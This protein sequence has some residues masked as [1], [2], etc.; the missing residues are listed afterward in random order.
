M[1]FV[2]LSGRRYRRSGVITARHTPL[3][4]GRQALKNV[5]ESTKTNPKTRANAK[6][7]LAKQK[8][9]KKRKKQRKQQKN[10][11]NEKTT[12]T[13]TRATRE[14]TKN[15]VKKQVG[16]TAKTDLPAKTK[17]P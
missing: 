4:T 2:A 17:L 9:K 15:N 1:V 8:A 16:R 6:A 13:K 10:T 12:T 14:K 7:K 11:K 3:A 5:A